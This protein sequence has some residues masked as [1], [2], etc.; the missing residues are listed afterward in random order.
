MIKQAYD[1][2]E[3]FT[4][5]SHNPDSVSLTNAQRYWCEN[6]ANRNKLIS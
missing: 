5:E 4:K 3:R 2:F 6:L 1:G